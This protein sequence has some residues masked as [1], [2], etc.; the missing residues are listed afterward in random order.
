M[1]EVPEIPR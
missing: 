1:V